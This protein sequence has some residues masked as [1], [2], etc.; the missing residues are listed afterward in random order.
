MTNSKFVLCATS[1]IHSRSG[2]RA[3]GLFAGHYFSYTKD[4]HTGKWFNFN[5]MDVRAIS[6]RDARRMCGQD[7]PS[8]S[9][10]NAY[11]LLYRRMAV[12]ESLHIDGAIVPEYIR[13]LIETENDEIKDKKRDYEEAMKNVSVNVFCAMGDREE[14]P[15]PMLLDR[16]L[17][18]EAAAREMARRLQWDCDAYEYRVR[19]YLP[20]RGKVT[21]ESFAGRE[22]DTLH[23][24]AFHNN[25][26]VFLERK[27]VGE[28]WKVRSNGMRVC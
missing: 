10:T 12:G 17:S 21:G 4:T 5:D 6:E 25:K 3:L 16:T 13:K 7:G 11:M 27:R 8:V 18:V 9:S 2:C 19:G 23:A 22:K 20:K 24:L 15:K 14:V 1:I 28:D 26:N